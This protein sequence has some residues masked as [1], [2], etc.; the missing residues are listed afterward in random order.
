MHG[1]DMA[2]VTIQSRDDEP[3]G[4]AKA[5]A[6]LESYFVADARDHPALA[7][8]L[9]DATGARSALFEPVVREGTVAGVIILSGAST[10]PRRRSR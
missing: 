3:R 6:S 8:P 2:P 1:V 7:Q 4:A 10:S 9:V 5:F